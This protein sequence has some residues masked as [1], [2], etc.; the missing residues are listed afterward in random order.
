MFDDSEPDPS[1]IDLAVFVERPPRVV[2]RAL[3]EPELIAG[4]LSP[5][6]GFAPVVGTTFIVQVAVRDRPDAEM[7]CQVV[8]ADEPGHL[9]YSW[10]DLRGNPPQRWMMDYRL[11]PHGRGTRLFWQMSGFDIAD[12][13]Q[14]YARNGIERSWNRTLLPRLADVVNMLGDTP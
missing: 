7:A 13:Y 11:L 12:R 3:T 14:R 10:T 8:A 6:I 5:V 4:W 9:A 2:W 1:L